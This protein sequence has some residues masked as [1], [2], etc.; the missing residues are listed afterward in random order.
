MSHNQDCLPVFFPGCCDIV[1]GCRRPQIKSW[2]RTRLKP[3]GVFL[4]IIHGIA[5]FLLVEKAG[6]AADITLALKPMG[7]VNKGNQWPD[8]MDLDP[9]K[10]LKN[11][12]VHHLKQFTCYPC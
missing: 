9:T 11:Q 7:R 12:K 10:F 6:V 3:V 2:G 8:K 1:S 5:R 4:F